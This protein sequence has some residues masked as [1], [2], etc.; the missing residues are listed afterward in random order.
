MHK[1]TGPEWFAS[2]YQRAGEKKFRA[3]TRLSV[4]TGI[5]VK[6]LSRV[7]DRK[8][9]TPKTAAAI[10]KVA[11]EALDRESLVFPVAPR[12]RAG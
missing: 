5:T 12:R 10:A 8:P 9:V 7:L 4:D 11:G 1:L 3:L 6:T 2:V